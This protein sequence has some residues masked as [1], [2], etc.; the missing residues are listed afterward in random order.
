M[1]N[2]IGS[3]YKFGSVVK[4]SN[5]KAA[6]SEITWDK[7][8]F[9]ISAVSRYKVAPYFRLRDFIILSELFKI[10]ISRFE[11]NCKA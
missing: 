6:N 1:L 4:A 3:Q 10:I 9:C 2:R 8:P 5:A 11:Y 7:R